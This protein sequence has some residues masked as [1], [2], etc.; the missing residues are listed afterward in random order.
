MPLNQL[1]TIFGAPDMRPHSD[2]LRT[3]CAGYARFP[4]FHIEVLLAAHNLRC[5][6]PRTRAIRACS[7]RKG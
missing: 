4:I 3:V 1:D 5:E 2:R 6:H 7:L